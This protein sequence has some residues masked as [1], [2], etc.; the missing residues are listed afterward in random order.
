MCCNCLV[1]IEFYDSLKSVAVENIAW[2][3]QK[4][5]KKNATVKTYC[6][7]NKKLLHCVSDNTKWVR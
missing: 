5:T 2:N 4:F 6:K 1:L 3:Q 7:C